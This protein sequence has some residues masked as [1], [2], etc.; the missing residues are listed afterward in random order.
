MESSKATGSVPLFLSGPDVL[1]EIVCAWFLTKYTMKSKSLLQRLEPFVTKYW[2]QNPKSFR[3]GK[4]K[5][6]SGQPGTS[7]LLLL[8]EVQFLYNC[9][10]VMT[11]DKL[12]SIIIY[13]IIIYNIII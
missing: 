11:H 5:K 12:A 10:S 8:E 6:L 7:S 1:V 4:K 13:D 9:K 3:K 2:F